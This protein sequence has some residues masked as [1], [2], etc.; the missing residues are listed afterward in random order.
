MRTSRSLL[1]PLARDGCSCCK[2]SVVGHLVRLSAC[3]T[4]VPCALGTVQVRKW[5]YEIPGFPWTDE[6]SRA[7]PRYPSGQE[8]QAYL[9]RYA[10]DAGL[11][12]LTR[13]NVN[14]HT[15][16]PVSDGAPATAGATPGA[17]GWEV[18]WEDSKG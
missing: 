5:H 13:F 11:L 9:E 3:M 17:A 14:V 7:D 18:E 2:P 16:R 10:H 4:S 12:P 15:V 6:L 1:L 8:V